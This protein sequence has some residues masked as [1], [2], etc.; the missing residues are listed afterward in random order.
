[1]RKKLYITSL[2]LLLV[3]PVWIIVLFNGLKPEFP[4]FP[5]SVKL[6][7]I[8]V[9]VFLIVL[10]QTIDYHKDNSFKTRFVY[11]SMSFLPLIAVS[12]TPIDQLIIET[13]N[14]VWIALLLS[15]YSIFA[16]HTGV[17]SVNPSRGIE[18]ISFSIT[19]VSF[20]LAIGAIIS[21]NTLFF[22]SWLIS[23][24]AVLVLSIAILFK[25][26]PVDLT[27]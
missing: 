14:L 3:L 24:F 8:L 7:F 18:K 20:A 17:L 26:K 2:F 5:Y 12:F 4:E 27:D 11:T 9:S 13:S 10:N 6:S 15:I 23:I 25:K 19:A 22:S 1:M 21:G 16:N